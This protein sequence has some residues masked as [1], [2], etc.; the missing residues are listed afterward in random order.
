M[1]DYNIEKEVWLRTFIGMLGLRD[2]PKAI[3]D[4]ITLYGYGFEGAGFHFKDYFY[5]DEKEYGLFEPSTLMLTV[6]CPPIDLP[7]TEGLIYV[8]PYRYF[9]N[10]LDE[11]IRTTSYREHPKR[12]A[13]INALMGQLY[14]AFKLGEKDPGVWEPYTVEKPDEIWFLG[15]WV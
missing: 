10:K 13:E 3:N 5:D 4:F 6:G 11:Y 8:M 1:V 14:D 15:R 2:L 12:I 9:Y 7:Y